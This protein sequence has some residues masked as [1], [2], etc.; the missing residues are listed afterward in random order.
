MDNEYALS[1][2]LKS[3]KEGQKVEKHLESTMK[4]QQS[5]SP[6]LF[7]MY[8]ILFWIFAQVWFQ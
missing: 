7:L 4:H 1:D 8:F 6:M 3:T 5:G 2:A